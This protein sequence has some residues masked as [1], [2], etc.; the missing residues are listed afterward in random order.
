MQPDYTK[1]ISNLRLHVIALQ[2]A[3]RYLEKPQRK[4]PAGTAVQSR[5]RRPL[6][7][8]TASLGRADAARWPRG[9]RAVPQRVKH[10]PAN[11]SAAAPC[12]P[13]KKNPHC[14]EQWGFLFWACVK[15]N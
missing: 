7:R 13:G 12:V 10:R 8:L 14:C 1:T 2:A 9:G 15:I 4:I 5:T 3:I 6:L 11:P